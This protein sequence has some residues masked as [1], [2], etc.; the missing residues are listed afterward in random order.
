MVQKI[1]FIDIE[2]YRN[3]DNNKYFPNNKEDWEK[4]LI[5]VYFAGMYGYML[6]FHYDKL[7]KEAEKNEI[8]FLQKNR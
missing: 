7:E 1:M 3:R 2:K 8:Q 5:K 4:F 6:C